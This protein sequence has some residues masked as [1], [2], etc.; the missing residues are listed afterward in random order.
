MSDKTKTF[1]QLPY[2]T[3]LICTNVHGA[4][5]RF[6]RLEFHNLIITHGMW[7]EKGA[8]ALTVM[9]GKI[10]DCACSD[11]AKPDCG[12]LGRS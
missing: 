4:H 6:A 9:V 10:V 2:L 5:E 3:T 1:G 8:N 7:V 12:G 11:G